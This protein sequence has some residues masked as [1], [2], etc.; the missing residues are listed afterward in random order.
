M[1]LLPSVCACNA[2]FISHNVEESVI[3][4]GL[5]MAINYSGIQHPTGLIL[6]FLGIRYLPPLVGSISTLCREQIHASDGYA[7]VSLGICKRL[8]HTSPHTSNTV[9]FGSSG[10]RCS[11]VARSKELDE[12]WSVRESLFNPKDWPHASA[13]VTSARCSMRKPLGVPVE[14]DVKTLH[15]AFSGRLNGPPRDST[16]GGMC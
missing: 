12:N 15:S 13:Q 14:P 2:V 11:N 6:H 3:T 8:T 4:S 1:Y 10:I 9:P 7:K 16:D 5:L